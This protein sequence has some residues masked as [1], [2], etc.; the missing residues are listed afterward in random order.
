[1][2]SQECNMIIPY[3]VKFHLQCISI[4][5]I[6]LNKKLSRLEIIVWSISDLKKLSDTDN[7]PDE[8][9]RNGWKRMLVSKFLIK[10]FRFRV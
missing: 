6:N 7:D 8:G 3:S 4:V 9:I 2:S 5:M 10:G 1:M